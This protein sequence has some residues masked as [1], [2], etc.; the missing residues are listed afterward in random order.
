M[1]VTVVSSVVAGCAD[2]DFN[3]RYNGILITCA[4][5]PIYF[6]EL[7]F[8]QE[9]ATTSCCRTCHNAGLAAQTQHGKSGQGIR[10]YS[11]C[12]IE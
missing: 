2:L 8:T 5:I 1:C 10:L 11:N 9:Y 7:C 4:A 12:I 6:P 3:A